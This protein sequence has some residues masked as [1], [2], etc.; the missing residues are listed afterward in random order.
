ME[1]LDYNA[2]LIECSINVIGSSEAEII[3]QIY[4]ERVVPL[5]GTLL[6]VC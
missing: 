1:N 3:H 2:V 5:L 4:F 6:L